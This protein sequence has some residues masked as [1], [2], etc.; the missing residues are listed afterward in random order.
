MATLAIHGGSPVRTRPLPKWPVW[1]DDEI[2]GLIEVVKSGKWG[3]IHG[4]KVAEFERQFASYHNAKHGVCVNS[5]TT[6]LT[7]ALRAVGVGPGDEVI[8]PGYTFI[9]T[10]TA[11]LE[12]GAI[13][14]M[15][16]IDPETYNIDVEQIESHITDKTQA[17]LPVHFAGRSADMDAIRAVANKH[18]LK[19]VE[20]AAQAW[21]SEW[22]GQKVGAL[23]NA[24]C[25][26][27]QSSKNVNAGEG[28]IILTNEDDTEKYARSFSN[29]GRLPDGVWY[30]H[31][32][33]GGN[34]RMTEFQGAVLQAQFARYPE[35]Q[36]TREK[37]ADFLDEHLGAI[38]GVEILKK[39]S[40]ITRNSRH[41]YIWRYKKEAFHQVPKARFLEAIKAEGV[42]MSG[43]YSIPLYEQPVMK[44]KTFGPAGK[45]VDFPVDFAAMFLPET[46]RACDDEAIWIT[47]AMLLG[48]ED[49]MLD[50]V[51]AVKK[52]QDHARELME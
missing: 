6:A 12:A 14:I 19:I 49:D 2:N 46:K 35:M 50:F 42:F 45:T 52:V 24:G 4:K 39:D 33:L 17:I 34:Y 23:G 40:R 13:P 51:N 21:G 7:I 1:N 20:D 3:R 9:A 43:G 47:Q 8:M 48:N 37:N 10:A 5:G 31:Y 22:N 18:S 44:E 26:S 15:V 27:F 29:C 11:I 16:D 36:I 38:E 30:A 32:Y 25:F 41:I 28:G